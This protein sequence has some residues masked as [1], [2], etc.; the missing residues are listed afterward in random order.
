MQL[1]NVSLDDKYTLE[2]GRIFLTG[3]QALVRLPLMQKERDRA[4]G[5]NTAGFISGYR[6]SPLAGYDQSLWKASK[7]LKENDIQFE[8]GVNEDLAAT[9]VWGSQQLNMFK[10]ARYDGVFGLWYGKGPGV[11]RTGDVF[12]HAN[13][14]GTS[15]YGGVL[16]LAGDDHGIVSSSIAHQSEHSF[17]GWMMPVLHPAN[18]QEILDYGLLGIEM[19]RFSGLWIGFKCISET[20]EGGASVYVSPTR[21]NFIRPNIEMPEGG[22]NIQPHDNRFDQEIRLN[23]HKIYAARAFARANHIDRVTMDSPKR[24]FGIVTVGKSYYDV[25]QALRDLGIDDDLAAE[26]GLTVYKV[27]MPWPLEPDGIRQFAEGLEE[28]LVIEE[29]R[30]VIENQM[31]E[32]LYNWDTGVR[33]RILGKFDEDKKP[34]QPSTGELTPAMVARTIAAR[35]RRFY[36]SDSIENRLAFLDRKEKQLDAKPA[37]LVRTPFYCSGCPHNTS[38]VVPEGSRAVAGIGCHFMVTWMNRNTDTFTQMGGEGVPW[39]GQQH[40]TDEQHIFANL[41]D[42]T[43]HHSGILAIRQAVA[44]KANMTYKILYND[45]VAMTG[46]QSLGDNFT[47]WQIAQQLEGEGV[48]VIRVVTDEPEKYPEGTPWPKGTTIHHRDDLDKIQRHL[49]EEKGVSILIYDQTCAAEKRRRRKRG[50]FPDP[51][52]RVIINDLVCEGCGDCSVKSNCLSVEPIETEFG[53]KRTI[54]Q[55]TCNKDFSC[56]KGFCPSFVTIEGGE[57]RKAAP[58]AAENP[59]EGLPAPAARELNGPYRI[60]ITG[61]GGTGVVTIGAIVGM[62]AHLE[63]KGISVLD[64][65][66][67]AQKGGAVTSHVHIAPKPEDINAVRIP[68][69]RA[70]LLIGCDMVVSGSYDSLA[71][72]DVNVAHAVINAHPSPTMDFTL[73]PDAPFPVKDTLD[74]IREAIGPDQ[75]DLIEA[76]EIATTLLGD[77]IATNLFMLGFAYQ[78]GLIPLSEEALLRAVELNGVAVPFNKKAFGWGRVMA[79]DPDRVMKEVADLKGPALR[80]EPTDDLDEMI[81]R[82]VEFL[83]GYQNA[84]YARRYGDLVASVRMRESEI[85]P[86]TTSLSEAVARSYFKLLA[87]KD[88]YEVARLYT[89]TSFMKRVER[90]MDG[91]YSLKFHLA[92]PL[93]S[94]RDPDTGELKKK[95]FGGYMM[96]A[97][98]FLAKFKSLRGTPLDIFGYQE[99]RKTERALIKEFEKLV[100]ELM[101]GLTA[102]NHAIAVEIAALPM[103]IRGYGHVKDK[104]IK[105]YRGDLENM[106]T[107]FKNPEPQKQA[108]E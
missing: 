52:K 94:K 7:I 20:V 24:R 18:V 102:E 82:R 39:V 74:H 17:A 34:L 37:K 14:A 107:S 4:A 80:M 49:R 33:P 27:G 99:E 1:A 101:D 78:K 95:E 97:Y 55:S 16:A 79:A 47:P 2:E 10:G 90:M 68:A 77:S 104:A 35:I 100:A 28:V 92:P 41:G 76:S 42:G 31:K 75:C 9:A 65:A 62:A 103:Q 5:L 93:F 58:H 12:R 84:R 88:E 106:L 51:A 26:I 13:S 85:M 3:I 56:V 81:S 83:T 53:R 25:R 54:N 46:G 96:K 61:I 32:Q 89:D 108:A 29:K 72:F 45:A 15:K 63:E 71:K 91:D 43:Y 67:L 19:S 8:P 30:A 40:F 44:A 11:D 23:Q 36:T 6:G 48:S 57:L 60:L 70:D 73:D 69:G 22:L 38:T 59:A 87:Y 86:G 98:R 50:T 64:Q 66:G 21:G 105:V